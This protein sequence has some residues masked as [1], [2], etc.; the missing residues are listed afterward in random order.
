VLV[1]VGVTSLLLTV[2]SDAYDGARWAAG[3]Y[4]VSQGADARAVDAGFEW[5]GSHRRDVGPAS[6]ASADQPEGG[7]LVSWWSGTFA[8]APICYVV[9]A[10]P[11]VAAG[12][13]DWATVRW[14]PFVVA[15]QATLHVYRRVTPAC[16]P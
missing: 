8:T 9:S 10:S 4:A 16:L 7:P 6:G 14:R 3:H 13:D 12:L 5:V 1:I 11:N 2:N 15:G